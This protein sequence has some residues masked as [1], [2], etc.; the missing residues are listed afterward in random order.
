M[1]LKR[2]SRLLVDGVENSL[3]L[4]AG[5]DLF[6]RYLV[7]S[8]KQQERDIPITPQE[9]FDERLRRLLRSGRAF[10]D[11]A[12]DA[13]D[14]IAGL[15]AELVGDGKV[16][17]THGASRAVAAALI[18]AARRRRRGSSKT[19]ASDGVDGPG[20]VRRAPFRVVY[21]SDHLRPAENEVF[22]AQLR[23]EGIPV[24]VVPA[25]GA[26]HCLNL[27]RPQNSLCLVGAEVVTSNGG[28]I[29]RMG[30]FQLACLARYHG[31]PFYVLAE[32][33]KMV[34]RNVFGQEGMARGERSISQ[35]VLVYKTA[36]GEGSELSKDLVDYTVSSQPRNPCLGIALMDCA[37]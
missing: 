23:A 22:V 11:R 27:S 2:Q 19:A 21:I 17:F 3:A 18:R 4:S 5:T 35:T 20:A 13:R 34:K 24:A 33:H 10:A 6:L 8:L 32:T 25:N 9:S 29:S 37:R 12:L 1:I 28:A 26:A 15:A 36:D 31:S 30:T 16:V 14:K 7:S